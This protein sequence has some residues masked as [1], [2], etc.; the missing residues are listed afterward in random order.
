MEI[1]VEELTSLVAVSKAY[2]ARTEARAKAKRSKLVVAEAK[3]DASMF[4]GY[5]DCGDSY[6]ARLDEANGAFDA[7]V[8]GE[9]ATEK[10]FK[11]VRLSAI[12]RHPR[13][14]Q[15]IEQFVYE[16]Q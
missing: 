1:S 3:K 7:A 14:E 10:A 12:E 6:T 4:G 16:K 9:I 5:E 15:L 13:L 8:S 2:G 11:R